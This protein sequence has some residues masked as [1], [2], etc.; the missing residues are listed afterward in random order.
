MRPLPAFLAAF[1]VT[2]VAYLVLPPGQLQD[3]AR[4]GFDLLALAALVVGTLRHQPQERAAWWLLAC[5]QLLFV[6]ADATFAV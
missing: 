4:T 2:G 1:A 3:A 5:G 6:V